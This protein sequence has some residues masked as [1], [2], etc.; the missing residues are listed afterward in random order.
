M[1]DIT[2]KKKIEEEKMQ[3]K[4]DFFANLSHELRTPINLIS[5]TI[6]LI[7]LKLNKLSP[8]DS[9]NFDKYIKIMEINSLG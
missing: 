8:E 9:R 5:S 2:V 7:K 3:F 1:T 6:Q 4:L